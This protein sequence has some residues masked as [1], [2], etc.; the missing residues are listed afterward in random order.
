MFKIVQLFKIQVL[1]QFL[2]S[3]QALKFRKI[4][5]S[6]HSQLTSTL[7]SHILSTSTSTSTSASASAASEG[8]LRW[9]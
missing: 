7:L 6:I 2:F 5:S 3:P 9:V 1:R 4:E 8:D